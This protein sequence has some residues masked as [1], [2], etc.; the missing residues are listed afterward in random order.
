MH[1]TFA[2]LCRRVYFAEYQSP[3]SAARIPFILFAEMEMPTPV[4]QMS[5]ALSASP[6]VTF[7]Q[8]FSAIAAAV[9]ELN[10]LFL[11]VL[12]HFAFKRVTGMVGTYSDHTDTSF[13]KNIL[14][15]Y[16]KSPIR[17]I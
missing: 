6:E 14:L 13:Q 12:Y 10:A 5:I 17:S 7:S 16:H 4:P 9:N 15:F 8:V 3:Q 1:S 2:S 11:K